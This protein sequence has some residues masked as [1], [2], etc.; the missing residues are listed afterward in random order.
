V[1]LTVFLTST[2]S[3]VTDSNDR[4]HTSH[5]QLRLKVEETCPLQRR[6]KPAY[7]P[8]DEC[9]SPRAD[10]PCRIPATTA[11]LR[12]Y[13]AADVSQLLYDLCVPTGDV[14]ALRRAC[15]DGV[16]VQGLSTHTMECH[17]GLSRSAVRFVHVMQCMLSACVCMQHCTRLLLQLSAK[18]SQAQFQ[19]HAELA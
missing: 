15:V 12:A 9:C 3:C 16:E 5:L 14:Q 13:T 18:R 4:R 19:E 6:S 11:P 10:A 1:L 7:R 17:M 8:L 2:L